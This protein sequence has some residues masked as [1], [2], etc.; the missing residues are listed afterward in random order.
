MVSSGKA[1][2]M[3]NI[4]ACEITGSPDWRR[5]ISVGAA[6]KDIRDFVNNYFLAKDARAFRQFYNEISP[7]LDM[8]VSLTTS[9]G[10]E[11]DV[12]LPVGIN[13]FWPDAWV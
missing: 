9:D 5:R 4:I 3:P 6:T 2:K 8:T 1:I 10:G 7:D 11:E 13:F 12:D